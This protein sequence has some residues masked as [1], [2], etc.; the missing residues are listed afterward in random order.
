MQ[1][2]GFDRIVP[3]GENEENHRHWNLI[4]LYVM[5]KRKVMLAHGGLSTMACYS[6]GLV[7]IV[8]PLEETELGLLGVSMVGSYVSS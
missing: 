2:V 4:Q 7:E 3:P 8:L 5:R 1:S 6:D